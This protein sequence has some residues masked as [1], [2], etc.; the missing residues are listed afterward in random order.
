[1]RGV[2]VIVS[3]REV[4]LTS[5]PEVGVFLGSVGVVQHA[6]DSQ[7][8]E[9]FA[10]CFLSACMKLDL[11]CKAVIPGRVATVNGFG[12]W[13]DLD[14]VEVALILALQAPEVSW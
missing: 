1:M 7:G 11:S 14:C 12:A 9:E 13:A 10:L 3:W 4:C 5:E 2:S 6:I 8:V